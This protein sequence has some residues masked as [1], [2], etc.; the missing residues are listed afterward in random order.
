VA[1]HDAAPAQHVA[2]ARAAP[3]G[4]GHGGGAPVEAHRL[5]YHVLLPAPVA[6]AD[7]RDG[8]LHGGEVP[9]ELLHG[10]PRGAADEARHLDGPRSPVRPRHGAVVAHVVQRRRGDEAVAHEARQ[11]RF[12][13]ERVL[14]GE[15]DE[16]RVALDPR[17]RGAHVAPVVRRWLH[18]QLKVRAVELAPVLFV[19]VVFV[20]RLRRR[21]DKGSDATVREARGRRVRP[22]AVHES[23]HL[24]GARLE[25]GE[26]RGFDGSGHGHDAFR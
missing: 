4:G 8:E 2:E 26:M 18:L 20:P 24:S 14:P 25:A 12:A 7:E 11:R 6:G 9:D 15:P 21:R 16:G 23:V 17:V 22:G 10:E 13:V 19:V 3:H 5:P 1:R